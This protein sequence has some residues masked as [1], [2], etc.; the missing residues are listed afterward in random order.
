MELTLHPLAKICRASG[1]AFVENDRVVSYLVRE[2]NGEIARHDVL[3]TEDA[4]Y[5]KPGFV[6]CSWTVPYKAK[7]AEENPGRA[8]K[9]TAENIFVTLADPAAERNDANTPMLQFLAL[10][11][12]RKKILRPRGKTAD[13]ERQIFEH[14]KSHLLYEVPV[15]ILD[16]AFFVKIQGQLDLLVGGPKKPKEPV[17]ETAT[18]EAPA[19]QSVGAADDPPAG[20]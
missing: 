6:F 8:L 19:A 15:G 16:E 12:E 5:A 7:R 14:A 3:A 1:R 13:G 2:A 4:A 18:P 20:S 11:L 17:A 9:L 10:L